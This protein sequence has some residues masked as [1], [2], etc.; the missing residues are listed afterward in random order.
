M[1]LPRLSGL[2]DE[3]KAIA[4]T[5]FSPRHLTSFDGYMRLHIEPYLGDLT[6]DQITTERVDK[7]RAAYLAAGGPPGGANV[8]VRKLN[9]LFGFAIRRKILVAR[10]YDISRL[11]VQRKPRPVLPAQAVQ[12]FL[13]EID[14]SRNAHVSGAV[15][16][17]LGLGLRE[18]EAL[19]ARWEHLDLHRKTYQP[20]KT[21]SGKAPMLPVPDWLAAYLRSIR[22][23]GA[24]EGWMFPAEDGEPH[25]VGC[26][27]GKPIRRAG[28]KVGLVGLTPHRL[29]ATFA[30]LH[31]EAGTPLPKVQKMLGH[32]S[33]TTTMR[34]VEDSTAGLREAQ[35]KVAEAMGLAL[36]L[37]PLEKSAGSRKKG[38][39]GKNPGKA[40][41]RKVAKIR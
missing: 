11:Q 24:A 8:L 32:S 26:F 36:P 21:K 23:K 19:G 14:R 10:P 15:R 30:T 27:T 35:A 6:L 38:D 17:M 34:Y 33:I 28:E 2:Y 1:S 29:R 25:R 18:N 13:V 9:T 22:P 37:K 12:K 40:Q 7:C 3:W 20:G 16:M 41:N 5:Q 4:K 39:P 31:V